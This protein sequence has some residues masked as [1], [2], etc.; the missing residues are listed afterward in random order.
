MKN[1][2]YINNYACII[3]WVEPDVWAPIPICGT[4]EDDTTA[5]GFSTKIEG[6]PG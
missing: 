6:D 1:Y 4:H 3:H 2:A 5:P